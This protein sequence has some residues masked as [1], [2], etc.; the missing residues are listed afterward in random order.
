MAQIERTGEAEEPGDALGAPAYQPDLPKLQRYVDLWGS[1]MEPAT[2]QALQCRD[3]YDGKQLTA[4]DERELRA[5][6]QPIVVMNRI[7]PAVNGIVGVVERGRT[8]PKGLPRGPVDEDTANLAT[9]TL[10]Y[11]ADVNR[12]QI[13][14]SRAFT[15]ELIA[16]WT[17]AIT[18]VDEDGEV[19]VTRIRWEELIWDPASR[20]NDARDAR[21]LGIG[22][23][24]Y[25]DDLQAQYPELASQIGA[26]FTASASPVQSMED[27]PF[28]GYG[29]VDT[30]SRR[31]MVVELYHREQG[32][33]HRC[34]FIRSLALEYGPSAYLDKKGRPRCP[35]EVVRAYVDG[36]NRPYG[37]VL[38]MMDPQREINSRRS[39]LLRALIV[40][41][42]KVAPGAVADKEALRRELAK[43]DGIIE[44]QVQGGIEIIDRSVDISGQSAL[45]QEAKSEIERQ[46]P[47]PALQGREASAQSGRALLA[48]QQAGLLELSVVLAAFDEY[49][50]RLYRQM[51]QCA[52]QFWTAPKYIRITDDVKAPEYRMVNEP[53]FELVQDPMTGMEIAKPVVEIV[54]GPDGQPMPRQKMRRVLAEL[55]VDIIID[56]AP[57]VASIQEEQFQALVELYPSVSA[58]R[59]DFAGK[60]LEAIIA[61]STVIRDKQG[62]LGALQ[63]NAAPD[64]MQQM[65]MQVQMAGA[66]A[67]IEKT[68]SEAAKNAAT[69]QKTQ[70]ETASILRNADR[71]DAGLD[72]GTQD[73]ALK[74]A[75]MQQRQATPPPG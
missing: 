63:E 9:D 33:W 38:D 25:V 46:A 62:L 24:M 42:A 71:E 17:G 61:S 6:G 66:Q 60:M 27:R 8:D 26:A 32:V 44:E 65:Q 56:S 20:E 67:E 15:D 48:R 43:T 11:I 34:K 16:G 1:E 39:W 73:R 18:E 2:R 13:F 14:K 68:Q 47:N 12:F 40:R 49:I 37:V 57:D 41:Q 36:Q 55:D 10:R 30:R 53:L 19:I 3:F 23:W 69:A 72:P 54:P 7:K 59:P 21:F 29:W 58:T 35:I 51:W 70:V 50:M 75:Q 31:V 45:L 52:A 5:R 64:P 4:D 22:K 74:A 28:G